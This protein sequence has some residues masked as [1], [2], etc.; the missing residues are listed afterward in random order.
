MAKAETLN[1][2]VPPEGIARWACREADRH[3]EGAAS[4]AAYARMLEAE[5]AKLKTR[6]EELTKRVEELTEAVAAS[7]GAA[8]KAERKAMEKRDK[9]LKKHLKKYLGVCKTEVLHIEKVIE[10]LGVNQG[11]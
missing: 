10:V 2:L 9:A 8:L 5:N 6:A 7:E 1:S 11:I 4:V 3:R